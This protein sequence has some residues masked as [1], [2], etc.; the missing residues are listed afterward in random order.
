MSV[1]MNYYRHMDHSK[2]QF[3]FLCFIPCGD[4]YEEEINKL[5]GRVFFI[6]KPQPSLR[7]L[8]EIRDFFR[9]HQGEYTWFHNHEVY[10]SFL[11]KPMASHYGIP[12]F[13]IHSHATQYS[14]H[15]LA[16]MRNRILCM[17]IRLMRCQRFACSRAAGA[18]LFGE[19]AIRDGKVHI[20][21]NAIDTERYRYDPET[22]RRLRKELGIAED[23]FVIGHVGRFVPQK[24]HEFLLDIFQ[25]WQQNWP[26]IQSRLL[27]IGGGPLMEQVK[28]QAF[29][30]GLADKIIF[31]GERRDVPALLNLMDV[32]LLPS[33]FEGSPVSLVEA[34]CNGL[35]CVISD[36]IYWENPSSQVCLVPLQ[37]SAK[38]WAGKVIEAAQKGRRAGKKPWI[39]DIR[40]QAQGLEDIY[41]SLYSHFPLF[42]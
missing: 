29:T 19:R 5:G 18:F 28:E 27:C 33:F 42:I 25:S 39:F 38:Y 35:S 24:N 16:A 37:A 41:Q 23:T 15:R 10:L 9:E 40:R 32:F 4:S 2:I 3:D 11:L 30:F 13:I 34:Y 22:R 36:T 8:R 26:H 20:L 21:Y 17:P 31:A 6:E 12:G 7:S 14:D 1:I